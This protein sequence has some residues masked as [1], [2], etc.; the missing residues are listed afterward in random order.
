M[1]PYF[2]MLLRVAWWKFSDISKGSVVFSETSP[3]VYRTKRLHTTDCF[4]VNF[5]N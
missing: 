3:C 5:G 4:V 2:G 1:L